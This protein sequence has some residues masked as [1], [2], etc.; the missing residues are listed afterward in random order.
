MDADS[1]GINPDG[2]VRSLEN[3]LL[4]DCALISVH[5]SSA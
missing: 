4:K 1:G 3:Y 5:N 2:L